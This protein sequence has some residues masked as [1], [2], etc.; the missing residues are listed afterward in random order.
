MGFYHDLTK[1]DRA[2]TGNWL[3]LG[4]EREKA[5]KPNM[6]KWVGYSKPYHTSGFTGDCG[7]KWGSLRIVGRDEVQYK[8]LE[9]VGFTRNCGKK[10]NYH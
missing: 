1:H 10:W 3:E 8:L 5:W 6:Q 4:H 7:K 9:Q 2:A